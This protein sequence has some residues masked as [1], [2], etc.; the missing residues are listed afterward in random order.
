MIKPGDDAELDKAMEDYR[1][2]RMTHT[3]NWD[4]AY[5]AAVKS[6][7]RIGRKL[8]SCVLKKEKESWFRVNSAE[9]KIR[10]AMR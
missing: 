3:L 1:I 9:M 8:P 5:L 2:E 6:L 7:R 4:R 10:K